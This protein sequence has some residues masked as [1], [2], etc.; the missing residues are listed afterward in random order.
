MPITVTASE[1]VFSAAA[2][3][4]LFADLTESLL[5][6]HDLI[7]NAFLSPHVIGE[8]AVIP[9][10]RSF[11]GGKPADIVVVELKLPSFTL[12]AESQKRAFIA[13][14]TE[15]VMRASGGRQDRERVYVNVVH[16]ADGLWG[17]GGRAYSNEALM[18]A[19]AG[20]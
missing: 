17:I 6:Q 14:A 1:G 12:A 13:D 11:A 2:E 18:A 16:T 10:G 15:A 20:G 4:Q 19:V 8:V 9:Q 7:G 3:R 5:R